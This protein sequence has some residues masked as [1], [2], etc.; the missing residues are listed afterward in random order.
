MR[1]VSNQIRKSYRQVFDEMSQNIQ[2]GARHCREFV[3]RGDKPYIRRIVTAGDDITYVCTA[4]IALASVEYFCREISKYTL[5]G[6][7]DQDLS[8]I[9]ISAKAR[10]RCSR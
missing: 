6:K 10:A 2:E 4:K 7:E 5:N 3:S 9:H 1:L 8:L